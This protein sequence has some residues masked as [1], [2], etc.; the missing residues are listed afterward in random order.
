MLQCCRE[1]CKRGVQTSL[2][3]IFSLARPG[4]TLN[5]SQ[6]VTPRILGRSHMAHSV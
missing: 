6:P 5:H 4:I 3:A 2:L 1:G